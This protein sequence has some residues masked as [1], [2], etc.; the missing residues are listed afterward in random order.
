MHGAKVDLHQVLRVFQIIQENGKQIGEEKFL[1]GVFASAGF[2]DYNITMR[3]DKTT[4]SLGFHNTLNLNSKNSEA[5][6]LFKKR[7]Y[8]IDNAIY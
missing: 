6:K 7:M 5:E 3:D 4:L 1:D 2:D 8:H